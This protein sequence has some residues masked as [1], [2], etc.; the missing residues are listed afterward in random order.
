MSKTTGRLLA[1]LLA[2]FALVLAGCS[3]DDDSND[4]SGSAPEG[5][6]IKV[7]GQDFT[8]SESI[9]EVYGQYLQGL[10]YD[11]EILT[12]AGFRTEAVQGIE[13]AEL[14]LIIDYIGGSQTELV[15]DA[16]P[17]QDADEVIDV[18]TPA[19]AEIGATVLEYSPAV[20]TDAYVVRGDLDASTISDTA[21]LGLRLG[22][23]S[24]CFERPQCY[25]GLTDPDIYGIEFSSETTIEFGS[26]LGD[27]L[28]QDVVDVVIWNTT[29]PQIEAEGFKIL[30]DDQGLF[31]AQNI[32]P[33]VR[34][35]VLDAYGDQLAEDLN[36]LSAEIT[37]EDLLEWNIATDID[38]REPDDVAAEWLETNGLV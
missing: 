22:A 38:F 28:A 14:D 4:A 20:D 18:I 11:V 8:E 31:P 5:P 27:A 16:A 30:E 1:V 25:V 34:T 9:A 36:T 29:A 17:S 7:R 23:S 32:A 37:S 3:S 6:T 13:T 10:G 21:D 19:Y 15:P 26:A 33:I 2:V 24:Q 12:A 35:E